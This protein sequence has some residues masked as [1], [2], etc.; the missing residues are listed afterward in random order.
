MSQSPATPSSD[1]DVAAY[2]AANY[3]NTQLL[4]SGKSLSGHERNCVYLNTDAPRFAN[5]SAVSGLDFDDD[6][7]TVAP[8]DWDHDGDL[9]FWLGNRTAP[10]LRL[11]RNEAVGNHFVAVKLQGSTCN[12]DAIGA[13]IEVHRPDDPRQQ[14]QSVRGGEGYSSQRGKWLVFGLG[15][16]TSAVALTVR[17]P[18]G[19]VQKHAG[20]AVD[21]HYRIVQG[22]AQA[23]PWTRPKPASALRPAELDHPKQT[24][25]AR[26]I[27]SGRV[28]MIPI[29]TRTFSGK[30]IEIAGVIGAPMLVNVWAS[31]CAPC[32][33][34]LKQ[35]TEHQ[36][37][38]DAARL[39][40]I[41]VSV[42][43]LHASHTT[44]HADAAQMLREL[45]FPFK[46]TT[47]D[48]ETLDKLRYFQNK[49]FIRDV[50]LPVPTS[51]LIDTKGYL[52]AIYRGPVEVDQLLDDLKLLDLSAEDLRDRA[53]PMA[54]RWYRSPVAANVP[55]LA[56]ELQRAGLVTDA[57]RMLD[58]FIRTSAPLQS[59]TVGMQSYVE[60]LN[61]LGAALIEHGAHE[62]A[63]KFLL[64]AI[65]ASP[66]AEMPVQNLASL[67]L[68]TQQHAKAMSLYRTVLK[69]DP[70]NA[71]LHH[72]LGNLLDATSQPDQAAEHYRAAIQA[73]PGYA[74]AHTNLGIYH[75]KRNEYDQAIVS[76]EAAV[77][78]DPDNFQFLSNL[79]T[80]LARAG[81]AE[82]A[83]K[84]AERAMARARAEGNED[85]A[86]QIGAR[87]GASTPDP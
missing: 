33:K 54:G 45:K 56:K 74:D 57:I 61:N 52:A 9:D 64:Q 69:A 10:R 50:P 21:Q 86:Q 80:A 68:R 6:C 14:I 42:D 13:R 26:V 66:G 22:E 5:V 65:N 23:T 59:N 7:R 41:A 43:G 17:W 55:E 16:H 11:M 46:A 18:D 84:I 71:I 75:A 47:V 2:L 31:W 12:R 53:V 60:A 28:P 70:D 44:T 19:A 76:F 67:Y 37:Q 83:R 48:G 49:L 51:F 35:F 63:E 30:P 15:E 36:K 62:Q 85:I 25:R 39:H 78:L 81:R 1:Q 27:M 72:D 34:E 38:I 87:F 20:I 32:A 79:A 4:R 29:A 8:V 3:Q 58:H 82:D 73:D 77:Q 24:N 40:I